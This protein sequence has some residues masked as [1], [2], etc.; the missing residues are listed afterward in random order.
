MY[1]R[2]DSITATA[3]P[4]GTFDFGLFRVAFCGIA[5][6]STP[7]NVLIT[8]NELYGEWGVMGN[9]TAD[10]MEKSELGHSKILWE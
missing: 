6:N 8:N 2:V 10:R 3:T 9:R 4:G 7:S 1:V 5:L